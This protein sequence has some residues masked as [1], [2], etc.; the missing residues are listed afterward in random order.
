MSV[1]AGLGHSA[2]IAADGRCGGGSRCGVLYMRGLQAIH[3]GLE[4]MGPIRA[5][6]YHR[7]LRA[8]I[9][10]SFWERPGAQSVLRCWA[11][12][13]SAWVHLLLQPAAVSPVACSKVGF[14]QVT[15]LWSWG[16]G[17]YGQLGH[18]DQVDRPLPK[19][20]RTLKGVRMAAIA[21]GDHHSSAVCPM[22]LQRPLTACVAAAERRRI[23]VR[24]GKRLESAI[25]HCV[26]VL[27]PC[28]CGWAVGIL[29]S[30]S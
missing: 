6:H 28:R 3:L 4:P 5:R 13:G 24:V 25:R 27:V 2:A 23:P 21:T 8:V 22:L 26:L 14:A 1:A 12:N 29:R 30:D 11:Y 10:R 18:G 20:V 16:F 7:L 17:G 9:G 15:R 19:L